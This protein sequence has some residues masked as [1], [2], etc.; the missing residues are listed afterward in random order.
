MTNEEAI[1]R[2]QRLIA[3]WCWHHD[4]NDFC[5]VSGWTGVYAQDKWRELQNLKVA[6]GNFDPVT[7]VKILEPPAQEPAE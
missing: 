4:F 5:A 6:L 3:E 1:R 7:L 2:V